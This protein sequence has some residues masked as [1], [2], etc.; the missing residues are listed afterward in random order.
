MLFLSMLGFNSADERIQH[1]AIIVIDFFDWLGLI[2]RSESAPLMS[3]PGHSRRKR[4][5]RSWM[6]SMATAVSSQGFNSAVLGR[7]RSIQH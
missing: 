4:S 3:G 6:W 5:R 1:L 7:C 2:C